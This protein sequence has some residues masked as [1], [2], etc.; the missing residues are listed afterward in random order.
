[1]PA[2]SRERFRH[3]C[4]DFVIE[5]KS[6]TDRLKPLRNK[7]QE[8]LE[9]GAQLGWLIDPETHSVTIYRPAGDPEILTGIDS[10]AG[11]G[12]VGGL[13]LDLTSVWNPS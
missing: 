5:L 8:Y 12:P 6:A 4:P 11:E 10:I 13:T 9:N 1:L 2:A 3:L 7:M